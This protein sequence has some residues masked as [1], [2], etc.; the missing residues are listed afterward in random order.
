MFSNSNKNSK[1]SIVKIQYL[2]VIIA[3][4]ISLTY[5]FFSNRIVYG[6]FIDNLLRLLL[7]LLF[8]SNVLFSNK[9]FSKRFNLVLVPYSIIY[10]L[11]S[12]YNG[13]ILLDIINGQTFILYF[14]GFQAFT[15]QRLDKVNYLWPK[16]MKL[17]LWIVTCTYL[18][19]FIVVKFHSPYLFVE[20]NFELLLILI[21]WF[22][23]VYNNHLKLLSFNSL[24]IIL[25]T[26]ISNSLSGQLLLVFFLVFYRYNVWKLFIG[27]FVVILLLSFTY[28]FY[29]RL[30]RFLFLQEYVRG[31]MGNTVFSNLF[32]LSIRELA[33]SATKT[34]SYY[35]GSS[36]GKHSIY[37]AKSLHMWIL[38]SIYNHGAV[39][40]IYLYMF[41]QTFKDK[42]GKTAAYYVT[43]AALINGLSV[44]AFD[45]I[46][47]WTALI[48]I[49]PLW[50]NS[51]PGNP[52]MLRM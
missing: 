34:L 33:P 32:P 11:N 10:T 50:Q 15:A 28:S 51:E 7:I 13:Y 18:Y 39:V 38:T 43:S 6:N 9:I 42:V 25:S 17:F 4:I 27:F 37:L 46:W 36:Q 29:S 41:F 8:I 5:S 23:M 48:L 3:I 14:L 1:N 12:L 26:I 45:S 20:N 52:S 24:G 44:S 16:I 22:S 35:T 47:F 49:I 40:I 31:S 2:A 19:R 21:L 30:D